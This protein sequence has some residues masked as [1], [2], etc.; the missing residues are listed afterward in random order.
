MNPLPCLLQIEEYNIDTEFYPSGIKN[1]RTFFRWQKTR[2]ATS[3]YSFN[4]LKLEQCSGELSRV[5]FG[6]NR[7]KFHRKS[8]NKVHRGTQS[9]ELWYEP[10][11][12][13]SPEG[14]TGQWIVQSLRCPSYCLPELFFCT[15]CPWYCFLHIVSLILFFLHI[16]SL[17]LFFCTL[18]DLT[19]PCCF[20]D[21]HGW[22]IY[23]NAATGTETWNYNLNQ[24]TPVLP[25]PMAASHGC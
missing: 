19:W 13:D 18:Q 4:A 2:L 1:Y 8:L 21:L 16:V 7:K 9:S 25:I 10:G 11:P 15:L 22:I 14:R 12:G 23:W 20:N 5:N 17:I 24:R 3:N 6:T